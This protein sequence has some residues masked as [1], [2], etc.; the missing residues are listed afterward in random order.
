MEENMNPQT[1][2]VTSTQTYTQHGQTIT[3][4]KVPEPIPHQNQ[5]LEEQNRHYQI[6]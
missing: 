6:G 2:T 5:K 1:Q 4:K 3:T